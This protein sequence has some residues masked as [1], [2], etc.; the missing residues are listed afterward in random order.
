MKKII[1]ALLALVMCAGVLTG[2]N[3]Q[4]DK[5]GWEYIEEK[6]TLVVGL[7]DTFAPMGFRDE[8]NDLVGFDIDLANA[9][10]EVLGVEIVFQP[11]D[12][13]AKEL[14]LSS[15]TID[16]IWNGMSA[17]EERQE[18]MALTKK[19]LNNQI[20]IMSL[21]ENINIQS[22]ADLADV[23]VGTQAESA[24][25]EVIMAHEDYELYKDN[26]TEYKT[27]DEAILDMRAGRIDCIVVDRVLGEYKNNNMDEKMYLNDFDFGDDFYAIGC[28]KGETDVADKISDAIQTL[29]DNGKAA[30]ISNKWFG[31]NIVIL[32]D[33][34]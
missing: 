19:Y 1:A 29:I 34:K 21:D 8:N 18:S 12:W 27:Y 28:R 15:K 5:E 30:E 20:V 14:E 3:K 31:E 32:E 33:Y 25:L 4:S 11:I 26:V 9:V 17:T 7:D 24:A 10:G 16:C 2:C 6:G 22:A 13:N 23:N